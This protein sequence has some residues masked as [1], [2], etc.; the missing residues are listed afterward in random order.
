MFPNFPK[1]LGFEGKGLLKSHFYAFHWNKVAL[2][3]AGVMSMDSNGC[4]MYL[5]WGRLRSLTTIIIVALT[6][7]QAPRCVRAIS[8]YRTSDLRT[9][10]Y[11]DTRQREKKALLSVCYRWEIGALR[12]SDFPMSLPETCVWNPSS[13]LS[14][15]SNDFSPHAH[16][17]YIDPSSFQLIQPQLDQIHQQWCVTIGSGHVFSARSGRGRQFP[18]PP[19]EL[20]GTDFLSNELIFIP[21]R[22]ISVCVLAAG[23]RE[24][25]GGCWCQL[26]I[27]P[28]F[29]WYMWTG[30]DKGKACSMKG[31]LLRCFLVSEHDQPSGVITKGERSMFL[32]ADL[33]GYYLMKQIYRWIVKAAVTSEERGWLVSCVC[34]YI[35]TASHPFALV[36][37][38]GSMM[39]SSLST[40]EC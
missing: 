21:M 12:L 27:M 13:V 8:G 15:Q 9:K 18:V 20:Q 40:R 17:V 33:Q 37:V 16:G 25:E 35:Q 38:R 14:L 6:R 31:C 26:G 10:Q 1:T 29:T 19:A 22:D 30:R 5:C 34:P 36:W 3:W 24:H 39:L 4:L 7:I 11:K 32:S 28:A 23:T 2:V